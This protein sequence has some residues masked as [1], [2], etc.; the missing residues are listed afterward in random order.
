MKNSIFFL[1]TILIIISCRQHE[2]EDYHNLISE[3]R[4]LYEGGE[5]ENSSKKYSEAFTAAPDSAALAHR[6]EA[7]RA[8]AMAG[9]KDEAFEQ[10]FEIVGVGQYYNLSEI[11]TD[12]AL[13]SLSTEE[14]W[15][16]VLNMVAEN[17]RE[18]E[19]R[20]AEI[21]RQLVIIQGDD[22]AYRL[23]AGGIEEKYGR[24][25]EEYNEHIQLIRKQD[26]INL[27]K[28]EKILEEHGWLGYNLI[29]R[30]ANK[31]LFLVIQHSD[32]KTQEKYLPMLRE[33]VK[34][35]DAAPGDLALLE[36]RVALQQGK[37]QIY[38]SQIGTD[39]ETGEYYVL[40]LED[41]DNVNER[42]AEVGLSPIQDY[43]SYW[44]LKWDPEAYKIQL[45]GQENREGLKN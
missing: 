43:I 1:I 22:Q 4:N 30:Q 7:A 23:Q 5:F 39:E 21:G 29:G 13:N 19:A 37:K 24:N 6:Y 36:D 44:D 12:R 41:P 31:T 20:Y 34:N 2:P 16:K 27:F 18:A 11:S 15:M 38:G 42:R 35:G 25:S 9:E 3:A 17:L 45:S 10:L 28:V 8:W 32:I 26:S 14:R 33:A 40:P